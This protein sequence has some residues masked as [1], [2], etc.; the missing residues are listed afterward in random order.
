ME[1]VQLLAGL[2]I[3]IAGGEALVKGAVGIARKLH[4]STLVI[5]M[6]IVSFGTSAPELLVAIKAAL[7]DKPDI[8][9]GAI[10]GS[11]IS[12]I[13]FILGITAMVIPITVNRDSIAIDW[14]I[15]ML[16]YLLFYLMIVNE[17]LGRIEGL[18]LFGFLIFFGSWLIMRSRKKTKKNLKDLGQIHLKTRPI[19]YLQYAAF[20]ILG[21]IGLIFGA[22]MFLDGADDIARHFGISERVIGLTLVAFG[23]SL[24]ELITSLV[25]ALRRHED[26]GIGNLIGSNIFNLLSILGITSMIKPIT[27]NLLFIHMDFLWMLVGSVLIFPMMFFRRKIGRIDGVLL[28][29]FYLAYVYFVLIS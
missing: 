9:V 4:I 24:P 21:C 19:V 7:M 22:D 10:I 3:L 23:T 14:P 15:M 27:V 20:I 5:G 8:T 11:N 1:Y 18:L 13:T 12:N 26:I 25:A 29:I 17:V 2:L 6:T 16:T 28:T